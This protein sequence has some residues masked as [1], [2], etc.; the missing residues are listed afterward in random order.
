M[1]LPASVMVAP[2][3]W[4]ERIDRWLTDPRLYRWALGNPVGRWI[5]RRRAERLLPDSACE[6]IRRQAPQTATPAPAVRQALA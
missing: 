1:S 6:Q 3:G 4:R 5:T 2:P